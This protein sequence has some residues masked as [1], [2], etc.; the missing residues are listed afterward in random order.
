MYVFVLVM[1][2][3][4]YTR[5]KQM[6]YQK[7]FPPSFNEFSQLTIASGQQNNTE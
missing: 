1:H 2:K 5:E 6:N 7:F 4:V 3:K